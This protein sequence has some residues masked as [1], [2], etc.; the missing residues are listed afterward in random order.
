M[1]GETNLCR[2]DLNMLNI[3]EAKEY[4]FNYTCKNEEEASLVLSPN[5]KLFSM[6]F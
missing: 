6:N 4:S 5:D 1:D 2:V 3:Q